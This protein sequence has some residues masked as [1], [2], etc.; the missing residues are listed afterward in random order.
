MIKK[1]FQ[2]LGLA[3][4]ILVM[5]YGD[6]LGGGSDVRMHVPYRLTAICLA[7]IADILLVALFLF[8]IIGPL[9]RTR[10][11]PWVKLI[12]AIV[13]PP[14]LVER[15]RQLY[16]WDMTGGM[17]ALFGVIWAAFI[18]LLLLRFRRRYYQ[19]MKVGDFASIVLAIF[20]VGSIV[21]LLFVIVWKPA[22][23][24]HTVAWA[25]TPQPPREHKRLVWIL[26]DELSFDQTFEHRAHGL[27]LPNFDALRAQSTIF[28]NV[29]PIGLRT[30]K[31]VPSL[32]S[33]HSI[34]DFRF[35]YVNTLHVHYTGV[36]GWHRLD[37]EK[38]VF[39]DAQ[40]A[41]WRTGVVGWY[42]PYCT[43]YGAQ[44]DDCYW[45]N[46]DM[47]DGPMSPTASFG[48]NMFTPIAAVV[49][50]IDSLDRADR[51]HCTFD[52]RTRLKTYLDLRAKTLE[53]LQTD[54]SDFIFIHLPVPHSPNIWSRIKDDY[55][56]WCDSSYLDNLAL[57]D[58]TLGEMMKVVQSS[59]RW[60]DTTVIVEGDHSW[61]TMI[62]SS[63]PSWTEEDDAASRDIFDPRPAVIIHQ[64][65]QTKS[66]THTE[67]WDLLKIH[68]VVEQ[69]LHGDKVTY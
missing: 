44:I 25:T 20:A 9:S 48:R 37:G 67:K 5:N 63:Q 65:G 57:A 3:S 16:P 66:Q 50:E 11:E 22:P 19:V 52:V 27:E 14:Y 41:G 34:D 54:Q 45:N 2:C 7:Q 53:K 30:V 8:A 28:S 64:A 42:N 36:H 51:D 10:F 69:V 38:T 33:G 62:W 47:V 43:I 58:R 55:T 59:P 35:S 21:Q 18:L 4:L 46:L 56:E 15:T 17:I 26:F 1:F 40:K 29:E 61:R 39:N 49:R 24:Q 6:L 32:L 13:I 12:V 68:D 60:K 23:N 31:I